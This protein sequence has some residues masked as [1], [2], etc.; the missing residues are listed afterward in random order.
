[1]IASQRDSSRA[2][3]LALLGVAVLYVLVYRGFRFP[4]TTMASLMVGTIWALGWL[5]L[6]I[7]HLNI[8]S[9]AF[10]VMLIGI[11][12]YGVLWVTRFGK[13]RQAG[14]SIA[15][16]ARRTALQGGPSI[17]IAAVSTAFAFFAAMF[18]DLKAV[19]ELG[20]IA[21]C[22]VLLCGLACFTVV[23][24]LLS[25]LDYRVHPKPAADDMILSL[26]EHREARREWLAWLMK[27]P[28]WVVG[29]C[30]A[31]TLILGVYALRIPYD[32]NLLNMQAASMESV[33]WEKT[34]MEHMS[35]SSWYAVNWTTTPEEALAL[36]AKFE[37]LPEVSM[38]VTLASLVPADQDRK[39][40]MMRDIHTRLRKL[41]PRGEIIEHAEPSIFDI[42]VSGSRIIAKITELQKEKSNESLAK[43]QAS[44]RRLLATVGPPVLTQDTAQAEVPSRR[45]T[46][47]FRPR[48]RPSTRK[49]SRKLCDSSNTNN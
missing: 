5:T 23:P 17:F 10:A 43:V 35:D 6:T 31:V 37:K 18:A 48:W 1:M 39:I 32:H 40:E 20:W 41:P 47:R 16:A 25:I 21:G 49:E 22:G 14:R 36:K 24:A 46:R 44:V 8:L 19:S 13:E 34:L 15:E 27:R 28:R 9:S 2:S 42:Q 3:W 30:A 38:V 33:Q 4:V 29:V 12:D 7:G 45:R 26:Q 11:G